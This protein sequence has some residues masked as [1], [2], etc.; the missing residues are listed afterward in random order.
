MK[1]KNTTRREF[2]THVAAGTVAIAGSSML[3]ACA[4]IDTL[5]NNVKFSHGVAS[6]DPLNDRVI[7]WTRVT[8]ERSEAV[9]LEWQVASDAGFNSITQSGK[10][11]ATPE[12]DFTAKVDASGL[13]AG[14]VYFYRFRQGDTLSPVGRTKT[15][16]A[17]G[18]AQVKLAVFSC[19]NYPAGYFNVYGDAAKLTDIDAA[20]H[21]GDYIYEYD[22][23]GYASAGAA[24][25]GRV[26]DPL[27]EILSS[28]DYRKRHA[29]YRTDPDLQALHAA[30]PMICVWDDHEISNDTYID[31]A[32]NHTPA[33]EGTF[34]A[35]REAAL[36]A[37]FDWMPVRMPDA[38]KPD[39]I[40]RSFNFG[41][42]VAL[43]M[44]DTRVIGRAKQL[45]L[46]S[47]VTATGFDGAAFVTAV[48][49]PAR[50]LLGAEQTS[51]LQGQIGASNAT[52]Q[53]LGQQV[54]MGRM[55]I[56]APIA[57]QQISVGAYAAL[58]A[59]AQSAP[60]TLTPQELAVLSAPS[61]PYNLD[62]WDGYQVARETV[63]A[64]VRAQNKNLV[65]LAG[66]T[67]N[68]WGNDLLDAQGNQ[69]GVEFGTPS[70]T[71]PGLEGI[72]ANENPVQF[73]AGLE[74]LIG[75][76]FYADTSKRGF[77]V[78]TATRTEMRCDYR[79]VST[80]A[81]RTYTSSVGKS[82]RTVAGAGNRRLVSA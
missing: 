81:S 16:P 35:R 24:A 74:A 1:P 23:A 63:L 62:A 52:W 48:S 33:S 75:P 14:Q 39:R 32:Q 69:I 68:A 5:P 42:L 21:L 70:V 15:L 6:G 31:G 66:D 28:A 38:A 26:S 20:V 30:M 43:H 41:D 9:E 8:P 44:L 11:V 22:A 13:T 18:I 25:L 58:A 4:D 36:Q 65:V 56:P 72:F 67:H 82:L 79:Y 37:Y 80:I 19:S 50:Q 47:Y 64:T 3:T 49:D 53:M 12:R 17:A 61:I 34:A 78:V 55:N 57:L 27:N 59:R 77:L 73:A 46:G 10:V 7:L 2:I 45:S 40:Y 60:T 71:S 76:L 51:W 54:L 29:Q